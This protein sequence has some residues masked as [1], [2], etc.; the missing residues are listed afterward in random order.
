MADG[1]TESL[2]V[3]ELPTLQRLACFCTSVALHVILG[4]LTNNLHS[5][6]EAKLAAYTLNIYISWVG[7]CC[8]NRH[9]LVKQELL[10]VT[11]MTNLMGTGYCFTHLY[12]VT[13]GKR[14]N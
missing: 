5:C 6:K 10:K 2:Y 11:T 14:A 7:I 3:I 1:A 13:L 8:N 12:M 9:Y 4:F